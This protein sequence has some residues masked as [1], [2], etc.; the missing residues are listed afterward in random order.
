MCSFRFSFVYF[1]FFGCTLSWPAA[2]PCPSDSHLVDDLACAELYA[3]LSL[4]GPPLHLGPIIFERNVPC[5]RRNSNWMSYV[6][7][8]RISRI[9]GLDR[10]ND[11]SPYRCYSLSH[12]LFFFNFYFRFSFWLKSASLRAQWRFACAMLYMKEMLRAAVRNRR[13]DI[14]TL[15]LWPISCRVA[16]VCSADVSFCR[17]SSL[18][19]CPPGETNG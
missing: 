5:D 8:P 4:I 11:Q 14:N 15:S 1:F 9:I 13:L 10:S 19:L 17:A 7:L 18:L 2:G 16:L 12:F 6:V 3:V